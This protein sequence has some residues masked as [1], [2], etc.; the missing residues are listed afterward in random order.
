MVAYALPTA[1]QPCQGAR[2]AYRPTGRTTWLYD[3]PISSQVY[4]V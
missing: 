3:N 1:K 4:S 2:V